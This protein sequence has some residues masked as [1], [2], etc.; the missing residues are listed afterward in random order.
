MDEQAIPVQLD[1]ALLAALDRHARAEGRSHAE[2]VRAACR[3]YLQTQE[4]A[5][6]VADRRGALALVGAWSEVSDEEI[7]AFIANAYAERG[8]SN[9]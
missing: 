6:S 9:G 2:V 1:D 5:S 7:D 4:P 3:S 8:K